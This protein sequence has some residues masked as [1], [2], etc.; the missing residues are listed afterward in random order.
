MALLEGKTKIVERFSEKFRKFSTDF[1]RNLQKCII[2]AYFSKNLTNPRAQF[3]LF[4]QKHKLLGNFE[5]ILKIL[6]ENSTENWMLLL[7]FENLLL[8]IEPSE[9]TP[10]SYYNSFGF[11]EIFS[12]SPKS[13]S[14]N[15]HS[16]INSVKASIL[17][18]LGLLLGIHSSFW[19]IVF[20]RYSQRFSI[21]FSIHRFSFPTLV[22]PIL[23]Y[24]VS[25][26]GRGGGTPERSPPPKPGKLL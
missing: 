25:G 1:F 18:C 26:V 8:K 3:S 6:D 2:L 23:G 9:I 13:A 12:P 5:K 4:G 20:E 10:F 24:P 19:K 15:G 16:H 14:G 21:S 7:F 17:C 11:G 22:R